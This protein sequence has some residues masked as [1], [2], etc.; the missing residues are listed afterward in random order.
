MSIDPA[1]V[2]ELFAESKAL[3][4]LFDDA[5]V[6]RWSNRAFREAYGVDDG[7]RISWS[8]LARRNFQRQ[9]GIAFSAPDFE[10]WLASA[11]SRRGKLP[12]RSYETDL[13]DGRW[14][15]MTET[16]SSSGWMLCIA[17]DI[18]ELRSDDRL[19]RQDRDAARKA[20]QTDELTGISNRRH[21]MSLLSQALMRIEV[22]SREPC[23]IA[24]LDID[25][26]KQINDG[27]G[28]AF[29]DAVLLDFTAEVQRS[30]RLADGFG[31]IG[32]EEFLLVL[33]QMST[34]A[35]ETLVERLLRLVG[36]P[37]CIPS[38]PNFSYSFSAGLTQL[39]PGDTVAEA[40]R[41]A[42]TALYAAKN[43]GRSRLKNA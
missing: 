14:V 43:E 29:G 39:L 21:I 28:H 31:R 38:K 40:Y 25:R 9:R 27:Y 10:H 22:G 36:R 8:E 23:S 7:E 18:S 32:G 17:P 37:G 30:I 24:L 6:L 12:Y 35:T 19:L 26:F 41:R 11:R 42:D 3:V 2:E 15:W 16:V 5:D 34:A 13:T 33:P 4:A 1:T 20:S